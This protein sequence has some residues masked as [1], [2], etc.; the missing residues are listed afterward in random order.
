MVKF[1]RRLLLGSIFFSLA[2]FLF[3]A[4]EKEDVVPATQRTVLVYMA[5]DNSLSS[6]IDR[7]LDSIASGCLR[8]DLDAG[9]LLVYADSRKDAPQLI[10]FLKDG[11]GKVRQQVVETY[12]EGNSAS[13]ENLRQIIR[14]VSQRFPAESMGLVLW[15]HG[16][17]WLPSDLDS[18][19][20]SF[21]QD[22][23]Q[24]MELNDLADALRDF[25]FDFLL[26]DA[27]Y[28][29]SIEVAYALRHCTDY[30]IAS[31]TEVLADGFPYQEIVP[32]MFEPQV[33]PAG[34][35][36]AFYT[37]YDR[38]NGAVRSASVSVVQTDQLEQLADACHP[39]LDAQKLETLE[40]IPL[41]QVQALEYLGRNVHTLY[42]M[43]DYL[44]QIASEEEAEVLRQALGRAVVYKACT[45]YNYFANPGPVKID[46][47]S[48]LS[49]YAPQAALL[50]L[51]AWY[52]QLE[53]AR[54]YA[55]YQ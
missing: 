32:M 4:C 27:C 28:M 29:G 38:L 52:S 24:F 18:Y 30:L 10:Q 16:T 42:D 40:K 7:N 48:G 9:N 5:G 2:F 34:I 6:Y 17:A 15:S 21:G 44:S 11:N 31:P 13:S 8:A 55:V 12:E 33:R 22:G 54:Q 50:K 39:I 26:F 3:V 45:P 36:E 14:D 37:Y 1:N 47:F 49:I 25:H 23:D 19:L 53:W 46:R 41:E 51:N 20:R 35:A 43:E